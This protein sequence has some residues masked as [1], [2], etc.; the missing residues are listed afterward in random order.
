[1]NKIISVLVA[2]VAIAFLGGCSTL[3]PSM[4]GYY[5]SS[6]NEYTTYG[7]QTVQQVH[8]GTVLYVRPVNVRPS[9][10]HSYAASG[11]GAA[12]GGM[13]GNQM[14]GTWRAREITTTLGTLVGAVVGT[15][16]SNQAYRQPGV[17]V[18]VR[19][20]AGR[21]NPSQVVA[22]TQAADVPVYA[23]ER[24]EVV[25]SGYSGSPARVYPV[26]R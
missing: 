24:V 22:I 9:S 14:G 15:A 7:A 21:Y 3:P 18:T 20:D 23:G 1:M 19:L 4:S 2:A 13:I 25:G 12:V 10:F 17:A 6:A 5:P 26:A 11:I 16:V 8:F